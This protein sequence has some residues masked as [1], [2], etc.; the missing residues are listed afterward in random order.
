MT[1]SRLQLWWHHT[2]CSPWVTKDWLPS[3]KVATVM[4]P[5]VGSPRTTWVGSQSYIVVHPLHP[6]PCGASSS[7]SSFS[8]FLHLPL[9]LQKRQTPEVLSWPKIRCSALIEQYCTGRQL[10]SCSHFKQ[11]DCDFHGHKCHKSSMC[12]IAICNLHWGLTFY[13][14]SLYL[15]FCAPLKNMS[16]TYPNK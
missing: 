12:M 6:V 15:R 11:P 10:A 3:A 8:H 7:F 5:E 2:Y 9:Q 16:L 1:E 4:C 14:I 13:H